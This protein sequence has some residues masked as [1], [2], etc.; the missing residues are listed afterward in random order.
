MI[1]NNAM[2]LLRAEKHHLDILTYS[3][4]VSRRPIKQILTMNFFL[5]SIKVSH[6][7]CA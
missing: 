1:H 6:R 4:S 3:N 7:Q 5:R 2:F